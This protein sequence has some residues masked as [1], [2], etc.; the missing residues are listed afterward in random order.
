MSSRSG[1]RHTE[2]LGRRQFLVLTLGGAVCAALGLGR[3]RVE[4][5]LPVPAGEPKVPP[6][7]E[8]GNRTIF[9][10]GVGDSHVTTYEY[11]ATGRLTRLYDRSTRPP[12]RGA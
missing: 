6:A 11:D 12:A 9:R 10:H 2:P 3:S 8:T 7:A 5:A 1:H 4:R